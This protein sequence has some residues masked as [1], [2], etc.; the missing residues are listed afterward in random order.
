MIGHR[1]L[2]AV[3][4]LL[5]PVLAA[6]SIGDVR[7]PPPHRAS[8]SPRPAPTAPAPVQPSASTRYGRSGSP[9]RSGTTGRTSSSSTPR[10]AT[11]SSPPATERPPGRGCPALL[12]ATVDGGRSWRCCGIP[13]RWRHDQQ[14]YAVPGAVVLLAEPY[15][16]Y[17][18]T[19][20]GATFAHTTGP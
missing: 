13:V 19:D 6:C 10:T 7:R 17:T 18:S 11:R 3:A 16:W 8:A 12:Y 1:F 14:L 4:A 20:G 9:S 2:P 15:G 5:V